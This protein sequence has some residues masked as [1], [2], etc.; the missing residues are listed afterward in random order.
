MFRNL[1]TSTKLLILCGT[2]SISIGLPVFAVVSEK[3]IAINFARKE[4]V[5]TRYLATV[6]TTYVAIFAMRQGSTSA[7]RPHPPTAAATQ[8]LA[9]AEA[10][11]GGALQ[12]AGHA[13][14]VMAALGNLAAAA[15]GEGRPRDLLQD[16]LAKAQALAMRVGDD[17][18][19][20]L[21]PDLDTYYVQSIIVRKLPT[22]LGRLNELQDFFEANV[23][24][25]SASPEARLPVLASLLRSTAADI[26]AEIEAAYRGNAD[27]SLRGAVHAH[28]TAMILSLKSYLEA[29]GISMSGV[30]ARDAIAYTRLHEDAVRRT[31][32]TWTIAQTELDRLLQKRIDR[33]LRSM[34]LALML[35]GA[36]AG[37]SICIAVL[38]H[39]HIVRPLERL[40]AVASTVRE[41]KDY[42]LRA[43]YAG[44]DEIGRVTAA[45]NDMLSE[46]AAA[47]VR[48][49]AERAE[50]ARVTR[51]TTMGEMAASIAHEVNQPLSAI[52]TSGN[53]GLRWLA[54]A[55]PNLDEVQ[56]ALQRVVRDG[57]RASEIVGSVRAMFKDVQERAPLEINGLVEDVVGLLRSEL[58]SEKIW[59]Q[60]E[61]AK[62]APSVLANRVQ[63][64]QVLLNLITNAIDGMRAVSDRPRSLRIRVDACG[65]DGVSVSVEDSG[66]GI[67]PKVRDRVFDPFFTTKPGGMG[68]GLAICR[69]IIEA[70]GG[71]VSVSAG[72]PHG[73]VFQFVLPAWK[74]GVT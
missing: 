16:A 15:A 30:D 40:E 58:T 32:E 33:L 65:P 17:S 28:M 62:E 56:A 55:T 50:L 23:E 63:L 12:T 61:P 14:S 66:A 74:P 7:A 3:L 72:N 37:I 53:A 46:L 21:D 22:V 45:F 71:R 36:F 42:H 18:N 6:R 67:D 43:D 26:K 38:T 19:L 5:G 59:V 2:F 48:E 57:R 69:S 27:G 49:T 10:E 13:R 60:L 51:L 52:V 47:R 68:L 35:I 25:E 31:I 73:S 8:A 34:A 44:Q 39:R 4:L 24:G 20:T 9:C 1:R 54:H 64:Q 70:H 41:T 11:A 29:V